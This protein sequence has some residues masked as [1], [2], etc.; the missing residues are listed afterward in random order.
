MDWSLEPDGYYLISQFGMD[1]DPTTWGRGTSCGGLIVH[2]ANWC[3]QYD[4]HQGKCI[5]GQEPQYLKC[6]WSDPRIPR[7]PW[8]KGTV[9]YS[10]GTAR[11]RV[12][13]HFF[14]SKGNLKP[15][16]PAKP[17]P[18][19]EYFYVAGAQRFNCGSLLRVTSTE[20]GR[21]MVVYVEDGGPGAYYERADKGGRRIL[22]SSPALL[23]YLK[24]SAAGWKRSTMLYVEWGLPGDRPGMPCTPCESTP[25]RRGTQ[26]LRTSFDIN[27]YDAP[28]CRAKEALEPNQEAPEPDEEAPAGADAETPDSGFSPA[29]WQP[30]PR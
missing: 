14:D 13:K 18:W 12:S 7:P 28:N 11:W 3:C 4:R 16:D 9:D 8:V 24:P 2:Y 19:P 22:D 15:Y 23:E 10:A 21:C 26:A 5:D 6:K 20:N 29:G 30:A 17:F 1:T 27:H 25:A